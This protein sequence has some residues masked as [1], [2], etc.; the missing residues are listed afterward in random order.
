[1]TIMDKDKSMHTYDFVELLSI[2]F[3]NKYF[4]F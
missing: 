2:I 3:Y 1:M 4:S